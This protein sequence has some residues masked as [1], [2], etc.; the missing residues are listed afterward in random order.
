MSDLFRAEAI[1]AMQTRWAGEASSIRPI[2]AWKTVAF[3]AMLA[4]AVILFLF[5]GTYT[6]KER[7][8]GVVSVADGVV[9][10][11][12]PELSLIASLAVKD[13]QEVKAGDLIAEL[14]RERFSDAGAT[15]ALVDRSM[16]LQHEQ[17]SQQVRDQRSALQAAAAALE[18]RIRRARKDLE[19]LD[20]EIRLQNELIA[21]ARRTVANLKPLAEER[22]ISDL[23]YQQ[24][25]NNLIEQRA[26]LA[27]LS[28]ARQGL[29]SEAAA[30][31]N[32]LLA[33]RSR[34]AAEIAAVERSRLALEQDRLQRRTESVTELRA[35]LSGRVTALTGVVGQR[36]DAA[37]PI[38]VLIPAGAK[39]QATLYVPS[40]A[41]G[42]L[43]V[44][45]RVSLRYDAFPFEKFGQ[46][47]GT[48]IRIS[49]ID[50]QV[51]EFEIPMAV[52]DKSTQYRVRVELDR[53]TIDAYGSKVPLRPGLTL[54]ADIQLD[55]RTL[56]N[57]IFDPLYAL[58]KRL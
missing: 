45:Q 2:S 7:V 5:F 10:L 44:G 1:K 23:Q 56:I 18:D 51:S 17:I 40:S 48:I 47:E 4:A 46:Y 6:K 13:G 9:R 22:I 24:Q 35:P 52:K 19:T 21:S 57:W 58:G 33:L 15:L 43:R 42:F 41:V 34:S 39:L 25:L 27:T 14:T 12:V 31:Q 50:V 8:T 20:E 3:L 36:V 29:Q 37:T 16:G 38:A 55:S 54:A 32:E 11:R 30:V 53:D 49:D 28:R 26:R